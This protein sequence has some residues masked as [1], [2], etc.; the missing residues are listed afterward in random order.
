MPGLA[1]GWSQ[2]PVESG[3]GYLG[4][5]ALEGFGGQK[6]HPGALVP[7]LVE[8]PRVRIRATS[9]SSQHLLPSVTPI[10]SL[11]TKS[12]VDSRTHRRIASVYAAE[13]RDLRDVCVRAQRRIY[14][15]AHPGGLRT[16]S[17]GR[18]QAQVDP[19]P[20]A[21][22][23]GTPWPGAK[24]SAMGFPAPNGS[25][26]SDADICPRRRNPKSSTARCWTFSPSKRPLR[27]PSTLGNQSCD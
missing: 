8:H 24:N 22:G 6:G 10:T 26:W 14:D 19:C 7:P 17:I 25:S 9:L 27:S 11:D 20:D 18:R 1:L 5:S 23:L 4:D 3:A 21:R 13:A 16:S 12:T 2:V 15:R